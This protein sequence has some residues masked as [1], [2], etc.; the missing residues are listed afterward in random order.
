M[1]SYGFNSNNNTI[2]N[3]LD[4][5]IN[6][7]NMRTR[8][9]IHELIKC[10]DFDLLYNI[11]QESFCFP[12]TE[13]NLIYKFL[14]KLP[15]NLYLYESLVVTYNDYLNNNLIKKE[16]I[17]ENK[18]TIEKRVDKIIYLISILSS[19]LSKIHFLRLFVTQFIKY[20]KL[21]DVCLFE[22]IVSYINYFC[23]FWFDVYPIPPIKQ[24]IEIEKIICKEL[25]INT[26]Q[27]CLVL[28]IW[29]LHYSLYCDIF[30]KE[31]FLIFLDF[32]SLNIQKTE[33]ILYFTAALFITLVRD[34]S[35][36]I[37]NDENIT[38]KNLI[39]N[40]KT[41]QAFQNNSSIMRKI[42]KLTNKLYK[43]YQHDDILSNS[44]K[45]EYDYYNDLKA[46]DISRFKN[47]ENYIPPNFLAI[48]GEIRQYLQNEKCYSGDFF[49][50]QGNYYDNY[51]NPLTEEKIKMKEK[52]KIQQKLISNQIYKENLILDQAYDQYYNN[53]NSLIKLNNL[54]KENIQ[55][56]NNASFDKDIKS[57]SRSFNNSKLKEKLNSIKKNHN[58]N[59]L[60]ISK[61]TGN[62]RFNQ[63][64]A[65]NKFKEE[66]ISLENLAMQENKEYN[67][68]RRK[69]DNLS[70]I[71]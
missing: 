33:A 64:N 70:K 69:L 45:V 17:L 59:L 34:C 23:L 60:Y 5:D 2:T 28:S 6:K 29:R 11:F 55:K 37:S 4:I 35:F 42:I 56:L 15:K 20:L 14:F 12:D 49:E 71:K 27:G 38:L 7:V 44:H 62:N 31:Q 58:S 24:M 10:L 66:M 36:K 26:P 13:R 52:S 8:S 54:E 40:K 68:Y 3:T 18:S 21:E 65:K 19:D 43:V 46:N 51:Y 61:E 9:K 67:T 47:I 53:K 25:L 63:A 48:T 57:I 22:I 50:E 30:S 16:S 32:C 1:K 39:N 41:A